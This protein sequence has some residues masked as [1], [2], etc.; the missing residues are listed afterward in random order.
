MVNSFRQLKCNA[1]GNLICLGIYSF[2]LCLK[3]WAIINNLEFSLREINLEELG[4]WV[5]TQHFKKMCTKANISKYS[6]IRD[7]CEI[8]T[9]YE[10]GGI[11]V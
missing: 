6:D 1:I 11:L 7:D 2:I 5:D 8:L 10:M 4:G 3:S 9:N